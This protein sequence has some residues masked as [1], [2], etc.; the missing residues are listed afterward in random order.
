MLEFQGENLIGRF[1]IFAEVW[2]DEIP[3]VPLE[4]L[5][6]ESLN[7]AKKIVKYQKEFS[8]FTK[9]MLTIMNKAYLKR[10]FD[11]EDECGDVAYDTKKY[12]MSELDDFIKSL[13]EKYP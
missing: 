12:S 10:C 3:L 4:Q 7:F 11:L 5:D 1:N 6:T 9:T 2:T 13:Y 8:F